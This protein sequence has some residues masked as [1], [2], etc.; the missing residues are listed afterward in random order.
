MSVT[1]RCGTSP[2]ADMVP[3]IYQALEYLI[4][5]HTRT[6]I[7]E[8]IDGVEWVDSPKK[9]L[10]QKAYVPERNLAACAWS[11]VSMSTMSSLAG[12]HR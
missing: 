12:S 11:T 1:A 8:A 9:Q 10:E 6:H 4:T 3:G 5:P 7:K 2:P